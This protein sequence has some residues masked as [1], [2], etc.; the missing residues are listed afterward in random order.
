MARVTGVGGIFVR[1]KGD[2][3]ALLEWYQTH[4]GIEADPAWGG[5]VF[6]GQACG[7]TWSIFAT[8]TAYFGDPGNAFMVNYTVDDLDGLLNQL[9]TAGIEVS[10]GVEDNDYGRFGWCVD[11]EGRRIELWE[12]PPSDDP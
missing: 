1:A 10:E 6:P 12:P 8:D 2:R 5:R 7:L 3:A 11:P 9:R 4:L